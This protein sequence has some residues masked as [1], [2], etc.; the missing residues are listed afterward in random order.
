MPKLGLLVL[1]EEGN[2]GGFVVDRAGIDNMEG[3]MV[4][5]CVSLS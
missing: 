2:A 4:S 1:S 5:G 3:F